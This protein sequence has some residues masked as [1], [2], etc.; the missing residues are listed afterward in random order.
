MPPKANKP[1]TKDNKQP[2]VSS[3]RKEISPLGSDNVSS[4]SYPRAQGCVSITNCVLSGES[5]ASK[6]TKVLKGNSGPSEQLTNFIGDDVSKKLAFQ[7]PPPTY[8]QSIPYFQLHPNMSFT[9]NNY[10]GQFASQLTPQNGQMSNAQAQFMS[11]QGQIVTPQGQFT[12]QQGICSPQ[13]FMSQLSSNMSPPESNGSHTIPGGMQSAPPWAISMMSDIKNIKQSVEKIHAVER[14]VNSINA[15]L[16]DLET[17][18]SNIDDRVK[19]VEGASS[20]IGDKYENQ[21]KE[22]NNTKTTIKEMQKAC[23]KLKSEMKAMEIKQGSINDR[24]LDGEFRDMKD[25]LIFY[26]LP[27]GPPTQ[28]YEQEAV[29]CEDRVKE[30]ITSQ[31]NVNTD[32]MTF[33]RAHRLGNPTTSKKPR[34]IIVKF[35]KYKD[36]ELV[37]NGA[38]KVK[39]HL[40]SSNRGVGTQIPK[41]WRDARSNLYPV[42]QRERQKGNNVRFRADKLF[43]NGQEYKPPAGNGN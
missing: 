30:F 22:L 26:G 13:T 38:N 18:V 9:P 28:T 31:I 34:P 29:E 39:D 41:E 20:F 7:T 32:N 35:H 12:G 40:K 25:N 16:M 42:M 37:R 6:K 17:R 14:T 3:K 19:E 2:I 1:K 36:R 43:I 4:T 23:E 10:N 11:P 21:E 5:G 8:T 33:E 24:V 15:K 27:E